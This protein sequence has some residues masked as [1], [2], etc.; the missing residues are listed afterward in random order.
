MTVAS[1]QRRSG[2]GRQ[3]LHPPAHLIGIWA[4]LIRIPLQRD[5]LGNGEL[6][7]GDAGRLGDAARLVTGANFHVLVG[8]AA[9]EAEDDMAAC[10]REGVQTRKL[11]IRSGIERWNDDELVG[12]K[13]GRRGIDEIDL[14]IHP[15]ERIVERPDDVVVALVGIVFE[16]EL[17]EGRLRIVADVDGDVV[18]LAQVHERRAKA[19][20]V[21]ADS[22]GFEKGRVWLVILA[23]QAAPIANKTL[24]TVGAP[25]A[26]RLSSDVKWLT[27]DRGDLAHVLAEV[28]DSRGR[29]VPDAVVKVNFQ[30]V[31]AGDL[32]G[33]GNGNPHNVDSFSRPRHY[34]WHGQAL[35]VLRPA[36]RPGG[37][38]LTASA[39]GLQPGRLT[40]GVA[41]GRD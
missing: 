35:A 31:G 20:E 41:P 11:G 39:P 32:I 10:F 3:K 28:V 15:V 25:V 34:T 4:H 37:L 29:V 33:V 6:T 24:T 14:R 5:V 26:I 17:V 8:E 9:L 19:L 30:V 38:L 2:L 12:G 36:K 21:C 23:Q 1:Q 18:A 7:V 22:R 40:L 27:T 13:V 16:L